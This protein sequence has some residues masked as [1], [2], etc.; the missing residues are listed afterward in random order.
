[1]PTN[2]PQRVQTVQQTAKRWKL[3]M[4]SGCLT[5]LVGLVVAMIGMAASTASETSTGAMIGGLMAVGGLSV[6]I[7]SRVMAWWHHG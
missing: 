1:M 2:Q 5:S 3:G 6:Y 7:F 4:L